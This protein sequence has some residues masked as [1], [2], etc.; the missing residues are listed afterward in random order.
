MP[1]FFMLPA[2]H[3]SNL[4]GELSFSTITFIYPDVVMP[5][6]AND[7]AYLALLQDYYAEHRSFPSYARLSEVLGVASKS[8]VKKILERLAAQRFLQR[9]PDDVWTPDAR[10][11]QR[12]LAD[13]TVPAGIPVEARD[14]SGQE[15]GIDEY[16]VSRPS[17]TV[18]MEVKG[19][20]MIDA[21]IHSGDIA[22]VERRQM[23]SVGELVI[24]VVDQ[25]YTLKRL[26][27]ENGDY[28]LLPENKA[29]P[30][31]RPKGELLIFG[32]VVGIV[33][34]YG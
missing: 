19:D 6:I 30:V 23:A 33:R 14:V 5:K 26:G 20:S 21:G 8:V 12:P 9:T 18:L 32:A 34:R 7:S 11:F 4:T 1:F 10:F 15:F 3:T 16:L 27:K 25:E 13:A 29:Y 17:V 22:V 28:V 31:I 24:A 2:G